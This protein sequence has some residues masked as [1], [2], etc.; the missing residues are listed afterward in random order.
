MIVADLE[1]LLAEVIPGEWR[2][3]FNRPSWGWAEVCIGEFRIGWP[4]RAI[5]L[6]HRDEAMRSTLARL[7][8][9]SPDLARKVI[10]AEKLEKASKA[11][12]SDMLERA[13]IGVSMGKRI[14]TV[15]AGRTAWF[16]FCTAL[17]A[18]E[19]A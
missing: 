8:A 13:E 2:A 6:D 10:A 3:E 7:I 12:Q 11:L 14:C 1:Q 9:M 17:A 5:G 19:A 16:E 18:Y 15:N 4:T